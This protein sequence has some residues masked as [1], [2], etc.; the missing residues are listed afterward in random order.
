MLLDEPTRIPIECLLPCEL[1][2]SIFS[3][4]TL[5]L[6]YSSCEGRWVSTLNY[7]IYLFD[8]NWTNEYSVIP[9][10]GFTSDSDDQSTANYIMILFPYSQLSLRMLGYHGNTCPS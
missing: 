2:G 10:E 8:G 3:G 1:T 4:H 9:F 5:R 6:L 7:N